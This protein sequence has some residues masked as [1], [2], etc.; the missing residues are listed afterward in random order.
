MGL[1]QVS[2]SSPPHP[3]LLPKGRRNGAARYSFEMCPP[4]VEQRPLSPWGE[5]W[6]EGVFPEPSTG[7]RVMSRVSVLRMTAGS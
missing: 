3:V 5:G 7:F 4:S 6:G 1:R 2:K